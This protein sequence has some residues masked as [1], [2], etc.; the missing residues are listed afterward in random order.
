MRKRGHLD[1]C[2]R[3]EERQLGFKVPLRR[4]RHTRMIHGPNVDI[5]YTLPPTHVHEYWYLELQSCRIIA[6]ILHLDLPFIFIDGFFFFRSQGKVVQQVSVRKHNLMHGTNMNPLRWI[7]ICFCFP[8]CCVYLKLTSLRFQP[9]H[10]G[11]EVSGVTG[12][13]RCSKN[14]KGVST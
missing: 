13:W 8:E 11:S 12:C 6:S 7:K 3:A 1:N 14:P 9:R 5:L 4:G 2:S 10:P